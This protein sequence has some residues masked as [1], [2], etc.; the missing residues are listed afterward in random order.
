MRDGVVTSRW[1]ESIKDCFAHVREDEQER[2]AQVAAM[3]SI[4]KNSIHP[5]IPWDQM[6]DQAK[7]IAHTTCQHV[8]A[9]IRG[10]R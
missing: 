10:G 1:H 4:D 8:A 5:D 3:Y 9:A 6:N 2:C 7:M